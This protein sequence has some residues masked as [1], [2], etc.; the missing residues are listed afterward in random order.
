MR[1]LKRKAGDY[2]RLIKIEHTLFSLP[3][4]LSGMMLADPW[5]PT[6]DLLLVL[7][8]MFG[9]R[10]AAM[11]MNRW[12]DRD[13]DALNPRTKDREI[14]AGRVSTRETLI[15]AGLGFTL[16]TIAAFALSPWCGYLSPIPAVVFVIYPYLKRWTWL[17]HAGIGTALGLSPLGGFL[18]VTK[19]LPAAVAHPNFPA[20]VTVAVFTVF[21]VGC[22]DIYYTLLD[23]AFDRAHGIYSIPARFGPG[24]AVVV[25]L[26]GH[27]MGTA[28][29]AWGAW[30]ASHRW[31]PVIGLVLGLGT[32]FVFEHVLARRG[33][34][35]AAFFH[36]NVVVGALVLVFF[37]FL[38]RPL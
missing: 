28:I 13:L 10:T 14:P 4:A 38:T 26:V 25:A 6:R 18:A 31:W 21:W 19:T 17:C 27:L 37:Y 5:P 23:L 1:K 11:A 12:V 30:H 24:A 35:E 16:Y 36:S 3:V 32:I 7:V 2:A 29:V 22:F 34:I 8:A 15:L 20:A 9:A 33:R